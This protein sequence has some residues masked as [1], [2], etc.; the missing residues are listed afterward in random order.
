MHCNICSCHTL[1]SNVGL[2]KI[3]VQ[4]DA[5][6][7]AP[8]FWHICIS[9]TVFLCCQFTSSFSLISVPI[10]KANSLLLY[11]KLYNYLTMHLILM[12]WWWW[13]WCLG[14]PKKK[15]TFILHLS[16]FYIF[17]CSYI[18]LILTYVVKVF[19]QSN[20]AEISMIWRLGCISFFFSGAFR[21]EHA[22]VF[23]E[24]VWGG[25][26]IHQLCTSNA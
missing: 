9:Q 16:P 15:S 3:H 4:Y 6:L 26:V 23:W 13:W 2:M 1:W 25:G 11:N 18:F 10:T 21:G 14:S 20:R 22:F 17:W 24:T 8:I 7:T 5:T 19:I 12:W